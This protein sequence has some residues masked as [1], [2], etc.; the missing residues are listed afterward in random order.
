MERLDADLEIEHTLR[1]NPGSVEDVQRSCTWHMQTFDGFSAEMGKGFANSEVPGETLAISNSFALG[2]TEMGTPSGAYY[3]LAATYNKGPNVRVVCFQRVLCNA[4]R[5]S[6]CAYHT[7]PPL[8]LLQM[9]QAVVA[10]DGNVYLTAVGKALEDK[11]E[12]SL[13]G[14]VTH[15]C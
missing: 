15:S 14:T 1:K 10:M 7:P 12:V 13:H 4:G 8:W 5:A 2:K 11:L 9:M 6:L 3:H